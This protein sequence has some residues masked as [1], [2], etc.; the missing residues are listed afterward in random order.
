[1][2]KSKGKQ[3]AAIAA[4]REWVNADIKVMGIGS[5]STVVFVVKRLAEMAQ[6]G[7]LH[8][9]LICVPTSF[10]ARN[11]ILQ[12]GLTLGELDQYPSIDLT[13]DGADEV[14][15]SLSDSLV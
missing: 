5:G 13:L 11:L 10:Q 1:M 9:E 4:I 7:E 12:Y 6:A 14:D 2:S 15:V 8:P 3:A